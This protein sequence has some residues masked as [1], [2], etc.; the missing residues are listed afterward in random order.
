V[1]K[2][3]SLGV[4]AV[5]ALD[6][7]LAQTEGVTDVDRS[8][9]AAEDPVRL[10]RLGR[11]HALWSYRPFLHLGTRTYF[12]YHLLRSEI[13]PAGRRLVL[14]GAV[15]DAVGAALL[16]GDRYPT[17]MRAP[18]EVAEAAIV[19]PSLED[20]TGAANLTTAL[21]MELAYRRGAGALAVPALQTIATCWTR[22]RAGRPLSPET[23]GY[24]L[25]SVFATGQVA[26][27]EH[28]VQVSLDAQLNRMF[29]A[30]VVSGYQ[31][32]RYDAAARS[33]TAD[34][35][36]VPHD[37][38]APL[39]SYVRLYADVSDEELGA[40]ALGRIG[41]AQAKR[42]L[43]RHALT[44]T[45]AVQRWRQ[46]ANRERPRL[47]DQFLYPRIEEP[48]K[49]S[50]LL[51]TP[52]QVGAL[53]QALDNAAL[54]G[55]ELVVS[56]IRAG[57]YGGRMLLTVNG[58][59]IRVPR[60][61]ARIQVEGANLMPAGSRAAVMWAASEALPG[62][63]RLPPVVAGVIA[64][65]AAVWWAA[66]RSARVSDL[67][68]DRQLIIAIL[69]SGAHAM[70]TGAW[71]RLHGCTHPDGASPWSTA[72]LAPAC[73]L[74]AS[75]S[76]LRRRTRAA[77]VI[78][79]GL[80]AL[81]S[82]AIVPRETQRDLTGDTL[83]TA[84]CVAIGL[85]FDA[86][87]QRALRDQRTNL[88][89]DLERVHQQAFG[90]GRADE[91]VSALAACDDVEDLLAAAGHVPD[92]ALSERVGIL[93]AAIAAEVR[94]LGPPHTHEHPSRFQDIIDE[95]RQTIEKDNP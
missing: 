34:G 21:T 64:T 54:P 88:A 7:G 61:H 29:D 68:E 17:W 13:G 55:G 82:R 84:L 95:L 43:I 6:P 14:S 26:A 58:T 20:F 92:R 57:Q 38:L 27:L 46:R 60:D 36:L 15:G 28:E 81:G 56:D 77:A 66:T 72:L 73:M 89:D 70:M 35:M 2:A 75:W 94:G 65:P 11:Q 39:A 23:F 50:S 25:L 30:A 59:T 44:V 45:D 85:L 76:R 42:R 49:G 69:V 63:N 87:R 24:Q 78:G 86:G 10:G 8:L 79:L 18:I 48:A 74:G 91:L 4:G 22:S 9:M 62:S 16:A 40:R 83:G 3:T 71:T 1:R 51:L 53:G 33:V 37:E 5:A 19:A 52:A 31:N 41:P 32:G 12:R 93:R 80:I 47:L 90:S 67:P